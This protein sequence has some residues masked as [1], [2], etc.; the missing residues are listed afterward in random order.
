MAVLGGEPAG[1][2][3][4][5]EGASCKTNGRH[6]LDGERQSEAPRR[7]DEPSSVGNPERDGLINVSIIMLVESRCCTY[8]SDKNTPSGHGKQS[9]TPAS[10]GKF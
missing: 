10:R 8:R 3:R 2:V 1:R 6:K 7:V 9:T 5:Q 4:E